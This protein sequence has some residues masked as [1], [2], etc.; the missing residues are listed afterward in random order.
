VVAEPIDGVVHVC[1]VYGHVLNDHLAKHLE[2]AK[3]LVLDRNA[4][5]FFHHN[6][7]VEGLSGSVF[8]NWAESYSIC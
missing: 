7:E 5:F 6:R 4:V 8:I 3:I 1:V 2:R